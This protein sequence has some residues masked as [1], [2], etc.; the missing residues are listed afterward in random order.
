MP[1]IEAV[2]LPDDPSIDNLIGRL[3]KRNRNLYGREAGLG[4]LLSRV[5]TLLRDRSRVVMRFEQFGH[6]INQQVSVND[7]ESIPA[8]VRANLD[9]GCQ[10]S[11]GRELNLSPPRPTIRLSAFPSGSPWKKGRF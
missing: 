4:S 10:S 6:P 1:A 5:R 11:Y 9:R 8:Y 3:S 7:L 2:R